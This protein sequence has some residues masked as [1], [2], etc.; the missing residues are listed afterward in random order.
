MSD[1]VEL[2][3]DRIDLGERAEGARVRVEL[4]TT[5]RRGTA[6][7]VFVQVCGAKN[8]IGG[9]CMAGVTYVLEIDCAEGHLRQQPCCYRHALMAVRAVQENEV[10]C[11]ICA[12][13]QWR[14]AVRLYGRTVLFAADVEEF[15]RNGRP[16]S[17]EIPMHELADSCWDCYAAMPAVYAEFPTVCRHRVGPPDP[18][19]E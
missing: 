1:E 8:P 19:A 11:E 6:P 3:D 17:S 5:V 14:N 2:F 16:T 15:L 4:H 10:W 13:F 12:D 9:R 18:T 7:G